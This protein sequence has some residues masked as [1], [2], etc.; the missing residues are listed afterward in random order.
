M[1]MLKLITTPC[2]YTVVVVGVAGVIGVTVGVVGVVGVAGVAGVVTVGL[3]DAQT[4]S[5]A[6]RAV[7]A[8]DGV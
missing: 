1:L 4:V 3:T 5:N 7:I 6:V 2:D 8:I